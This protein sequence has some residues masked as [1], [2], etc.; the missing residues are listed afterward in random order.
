[1]SQVPADTANDLDLLSDLVAKAK[2]AGADAADAILFESTSLEVSCRLGAREDLERSESKDLG[3]RIILGQKQ[4]IVSSTDISATSLEES[5]QRG[6]AMAAAMADDPYCGL[7]ETDRLCKKIPDLDLNDPVEPTPEL[8]YEMAAEAEAAALAVEG[9]SNSE[10]AGAGW[11]SNR[12]AL[13]TSTG[14]AGGYAT[15]S[16]SLFASVIAGEGTG[17][18]RDYDF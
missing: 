16:H 3:L 6:L 2:R 4:A 1:M 17:M 10:S 8:L 13:V 12:I 5:L 18:E 14:F 9:V 7:A 11:G 15:S